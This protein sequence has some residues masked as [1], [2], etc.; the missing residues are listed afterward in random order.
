MTRGA[1]D[2]E[3]GQTMVLTI[4]YAILALLLIT[5]VVNLSRVFLAQRSLD[6]TA[7][8]AALAAVQALRHDPY[9]G[10]GA[11]GRLPLDH[12]A[13]RDA[14]RRHLVA[15]HGDRACEEF[16]LDAV[17]TSRDAV[18]VSVSCRVRIPFA[19]VVS[20]SYAGGVPITGT[21][22]AQMTVGP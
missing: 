8:A 10:S 3:S 12:D 16:A 11:G 9:Y 5:V 20:G 7:D 1:A 21:A 13:A 22:T 17:T 18:S 6:A 19:N 4:G 14:A 15:S 2:R